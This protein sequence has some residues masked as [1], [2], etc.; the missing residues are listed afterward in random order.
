MVYSDGS[1]LSLDYYRAVYRLL[2]LNGTRGVSTIL[3]EL[4]EVDDLGVAV[5]QALLSASYVDHED[6]THEYTSL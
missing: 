4:I 5:S 6:L 1:G 2:V 3:G